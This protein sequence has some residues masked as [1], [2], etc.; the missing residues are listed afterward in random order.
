M[1]GQ[2]FLTFLAAMFLLTASFG[3]WKA[4]AAQRVERVKVRKRRDV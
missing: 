1:D 2:L 4:I 3:A